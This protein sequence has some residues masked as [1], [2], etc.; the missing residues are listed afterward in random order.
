[1]HTQHNT[2]PTL[3]P[4]LQL[5]RLKFGIF[6]LFFFASLFLSFSSTDKFASLCAILTITWA[7]KRVHQSL[8]LSSSL[9]TVH[10]FGLLFLASRP[11]NLE[12][13]YG[14]GGLICDFT[15]SKESVKWVLDYV[16]DDRRSTTTNHHQFILSN[17]FRFV[18]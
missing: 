8:S 11:I 15:E 5:F 6:P 16:V 12:E 9:V 10:G 13:P 7:E 4:D 17:V 3:L 14:Y 2:K 18:H 1:M